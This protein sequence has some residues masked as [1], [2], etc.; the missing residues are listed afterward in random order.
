MTTETTTERGLPQGV[1]KLTPGWLGFFAIAIIV[2]LTG[3]LAYVNQLNQGLVVTGLR[4]LGTARGAPWGLYVAFDVYFVGVSFAGI[5]IAALI[6]LFD[7]E[8]LKNIAR[9]AELLTV[10]ALILA[11][12]AIM[13]DLGQPLRGIVNLFKY[14]RP[15]SPFFGTFALVI[16]GYLFASLVYLY[17][18]SRRDAARLA[19]RPS[20]L[21]G[22]Y[23]V[24]AAG[25]QDTP[26]QRHRDRLVTFWL[27]LAIL[28]LLVTA[29]SSLGFVFGLQVGRPGWFGSLQAPAFVVMAGVSG[30]GH[31][32]IFA[33]LIRS[34]LRVNRRI[35][36]EVFA[37]LGRLLLILVFTYLYFVIVEIL[38]TIYQASA[39]ERELSAALLVSRYAWIFW[40]SIASL[41]AAVV[42][43]GW[44]ALKRS[45]S[46]AWSVIAGVLVN[47][48]AIGKRYLIVVPSETHGQLLPYGTGSY[49]PTW[50]E[51]AIIVGLF[52]LGALMIGVFMKI[53][54]IMPME[55]G[56]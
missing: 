31:L 33:A 51:Y 28:P 16:A 10:V 2:T 34:T 5:S 27:A 15:Q 19:E 41:L 26:A 54:P 36:I 4:D 20:R 13:A 38:T 45:W 18:T 12:L 21:R 39:V 55:E 17:I 6:R 22:L 24:W 44:M 3:L 11:A 8:K 46:V 29:H 52:A 32:M 40:G 23:R 47:I 42:I 48:A 30:I 14:G 53:F 43:L 7:I 49:S 37:W 35:T 9:M 56:E 50:V 25:Y 1:G